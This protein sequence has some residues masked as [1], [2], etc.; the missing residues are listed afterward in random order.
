MKQYILIILLGLFSVTLYAQN[1]DEDKKKDKE[2]EDKEIKEN[3][4]FGGTIWAQ[5]SNFRT[6]VEVAPIVGYHVTPRFDAGVGGRYI[7]YRTSGDLVENFSSHIYGGSAFTRYVLI[8]N[9]GDFLPFNIQGRLIGHLEYEG[10]SMPSYIDFTRKRSE[11]RFWAHNYLVGGGLQ[12]KIGKKAYLNL[13]ILYNLNEKSY[14]LHK[15]PIIRIG[16]NF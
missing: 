15:N 5:I 3:F 12:Q 7:Y 8:Q 1:D 6:Q 2:E 11:K 16:I 4:F 9:L 10:L 13:L 14:S